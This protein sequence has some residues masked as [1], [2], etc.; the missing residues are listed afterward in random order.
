MIILSCPIQ[1]S[2][3]PEQDLIIG[4]LKLNMKNLSEEQ[5][6]NK[7]CENMLSAD[8]LTH[9]GFTKTTLNY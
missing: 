6:V 3:N 5:R 1:A 4:R 7:E 2:N 8:V 9:I